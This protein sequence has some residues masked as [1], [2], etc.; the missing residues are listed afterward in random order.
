MLLLQSPDLRH[1]LKL[2]DFDNC[3]GDGVLPKCYNLLGSLLGFEIVNEEI[4]G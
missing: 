3:K 2:F 1:S 4:G